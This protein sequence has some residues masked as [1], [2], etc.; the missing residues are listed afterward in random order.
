MFSK[1]VQRYGAKKCHRQSLAVVGHLYDV[2]VFSDCRITDGRGASR[3]AN[4][5]GDAGGAGP[6]AYAR[7]GADWRAQKVGSEPI[8]WEK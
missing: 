1:R 3:A 7:M 4:E 8:L 6:P 5:P 2:R